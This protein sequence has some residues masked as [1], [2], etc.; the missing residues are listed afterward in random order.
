MPAMMVMV[1]TLP[2]RCQGFLETSVS[3]QSLHDPCDLGIDLGD[4]PQH[5]PDSIAPP[6][7]L[8][9]QVVVANQTP[10]HRAREESKANVH[11]FSQFERVHKIS[12][13]L[14]TILT[15]AA[16]AHA[17]FGSCQRSTHGLKHHLPCGG[18]M[19]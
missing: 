10:N 1:V 4:F 3:S 18:T 12:D 14:L 5:C 8:I 15:G 9:S 17:F 2:L 7:Q 16:F 19:T 11:L 6:F 13:Q